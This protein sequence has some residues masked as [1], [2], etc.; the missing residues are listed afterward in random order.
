MQQ[1][2]QLMLYI[3][4]D[5]RL[6]QDE[7]DVILNTELRGTIKKLE[8]DY[9][10]RGFNRPNCPLRRD[11]MFHYANL[12]MK[13]QEM[14]DAKKTLSQQSIYNPPPVVT[15]IPEA[16]AIDDTETNRPSARQRN[17]GVRSNN[18]FN[19]RM[20]SQRD[21]NER[22][23]QSKATGDAVVLLMII[24]FLYFLYKKLF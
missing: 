1:L 21:Q 22:V 4:Q 9:N 18:T 3:E 24:A 6:N 16:I 19:S 17:T 7:K 12:F 13:Y 8:D 10:N 20:E 2:H 11:L 15:A 23:R 14:T 5:K